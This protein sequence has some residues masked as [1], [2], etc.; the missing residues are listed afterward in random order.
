[1]KQAVEHKIRGSAGGDVF[2]SRC[3]TPAACRVT[4]LEMWEKIEGNGTGFKKPSELYKCVTSTPNTLTRAHARTHRKHYRVDPAFL[5]LPQCR[6]AGVI[7]AGRQRVSTVTAPVVHERLW[8]S[9][10]W[11][12]VAITDIMLFIYKDIHSLSLLIFL[13]ILFFFFA[14]FHP[15]FLP[16]RS[17]PCLNGKTFRAEIPARNKCDEPFLWQCGTVMMRRWIITILPHLERHDWFPPVH[18][19][20]RWL[21]LCAKRCNSVC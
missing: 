20:C 10:P 18:C 14:S 13:S 11:P 16:L 9:R 3:G 7:A 1:M 2:A 5:L 19:S 4:W 17:P 12:F 6:A 21:I 8:N 15:F